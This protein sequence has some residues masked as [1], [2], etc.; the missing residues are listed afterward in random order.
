MLLAEEED[1]NVVVI[2]VN[3]FTM[4]VEVSKVKVGSLN[5]RFATASNAQGVVLL[6]GEPSF[7]ASD[8]VLIDELV[9]YIQSNNLKAQ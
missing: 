4:G 3:G 1:G 6:K 2:D 5:R 7:S 9:F 8:Q